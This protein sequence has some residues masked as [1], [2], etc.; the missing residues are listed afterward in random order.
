MSVRLDKINSQIQRELMQIIQ[1]EVD[2]PVGEFLSITRVET[3]LD[4]RESKIY[5]SLL[6]ENNYKKA[7]TILDKMKGFI[8]NRLGRKVQMRVLPQLTFIPDNSIKYSV[9]IYQKIEEVM[10]EESKKA[11]TKDD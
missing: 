9:E 7:E 8:R 11:R 10:N 3:S 2:D 6:N 5:F 1:K 4:L